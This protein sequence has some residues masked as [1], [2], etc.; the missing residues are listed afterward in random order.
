MVKYPKQKR[1]VQRGLRPSSHPASVDF[2]Q[3][4]IEKMGEIL[5]GALSDNQALREKE[6]FVVA[7]AYKVAQ[8]RQ[9]K[10][11]GKEKDDL[12]REIKEDEEKGLR[13]GLSVTEVRG[14]NH[15]VLRRDLKGQ[16]ESLFQRLKAKIE[17][18]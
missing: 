16:L 13:I 1:T 8:F 2:P 12:L 18:K 9:L 5:E 10:E 7:H 17:A 14:I 6:R 15:F 4:I 3:K 11:F